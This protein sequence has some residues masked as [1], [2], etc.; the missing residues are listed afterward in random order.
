MVNDIVHDLEEGDDFTKTAQR[1]G[2]HV[3]KSQPITRNETFADLSYQDV[4]ELF[5]QE[6][7][8][9]YQ[10][11]V[12]GQYVVVVGVEDFQNSVPLSEDEMNMVRFKV[13]YEVVRDLQKAMLDSYAKDYK[14]KIKYKLMGIMD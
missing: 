3:Y 4:R 2:L 13:R 6:L 7:N 12:K 10:T 11:N 5:A 8:T 14:T 1:F 9:P